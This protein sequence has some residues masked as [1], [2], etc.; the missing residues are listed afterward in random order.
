V[1]KTVSRIIMAKKMPDILYW[2]IYRNNSFLF[3]NGVAM[4]ALDT[5][6]WCNG[7]WMMLV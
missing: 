3:Q 5:A 1:D 6:N 2:R 7:H 4:V